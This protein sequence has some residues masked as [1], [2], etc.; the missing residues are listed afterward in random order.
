VVILVVGPV[1]SVGGE[2]ALRTYVFL[3]LVQSRQNSYQ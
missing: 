1:G 2:V 3:I